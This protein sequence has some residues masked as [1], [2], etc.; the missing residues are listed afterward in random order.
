MRKVVSGAI[1]RDLISEQ[2]SKACSGAGIF[3]AAPVRCERA[4]DGPNWRLSFRGA[5]IGYAEA[6][7]RI[8]DE[9]ES[10]FDLAELFA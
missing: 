1:L 3:W 6:W 10:R 5:P 2:M 8:R 7:D 9:F 4:G